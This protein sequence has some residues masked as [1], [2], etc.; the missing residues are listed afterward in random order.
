MHIKNKFHIKN[1]INIIPLLDVLLVLVL[2]FM[3]TTALFVTNLKVSLPVASHATAIS[4]DNIPKVTIEILDSNKYYVI[5]NDNRKK[6]FNLNDIFLIARLELL[7]NT[8]TFFLIAA[9]KNIFYKE[10]ISVLD[11]LYKAGVTEI[12]FMTKSI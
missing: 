3:I 1:E 11:I 4:N 5:I 2:I 7:K 6:C 12:G 8:K 10:I 9:S